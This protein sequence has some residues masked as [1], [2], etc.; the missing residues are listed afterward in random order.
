MFCKTCIKM[1]THSKHCDS[2]R[3]KRTGKI[4]MDCLGNPCECHCRE[5][6][7]EKTQRGPLRDLNRT[8]D[9]QMNIDMNNPINIGI[10]N[11]HKDE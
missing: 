2:C 1:E 8:P 6:I 5:L 10:P 3:W 7:R 9:E 11:P 4:V